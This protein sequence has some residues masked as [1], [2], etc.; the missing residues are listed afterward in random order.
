MA[1][2]RTL[3]STSVPARPRRR[4]SAPGCSPSSATTHD[5]Y[6]DAKARKNYAGTSPITRQSGKKKIV[7]GPLRP[8]RPARR[9][10]QPP[11]LRRAAAPHP[12]PAPTTTSY[13]PAAPATT[14]PCAS[15]PTASSASCTAASRPAP[16]TTKPPPGPTTQDQRR[17]LDIPAPG[18]SSRSG[19]GTRLKYGLTHPRKR[20]RRRATRPH[21]RA[22]EASPEGKQGAQM[23]CPTHVQ[24]DLSV[25]KLE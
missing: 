12:A 18:M 4:S 1:S 22:C 13:A 7:A 16:S 10:P 21:F 6:A 20:R 19:P 15:S 25:R 23:K 9:R 11:G 17:P 14:P 2:T 3:R 24:L 5:R 8:Q